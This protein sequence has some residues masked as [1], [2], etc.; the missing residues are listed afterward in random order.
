[1]MIN[2]NF[3]GV[4]VNLPDRTTWSVRGSTCGLHPSGP[5]TI[6]LRWEAPIAMK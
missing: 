2:L 5:A 1:M 3:L 6:N 4:Q